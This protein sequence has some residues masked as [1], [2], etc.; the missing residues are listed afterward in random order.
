MGYSGKL[1]HEKNRNKKYRD[2]VSLI[3]LL[4]TSLTQW[5]LKSFPFAEGRFFIRAAYSMHG[6]W[7]L[8]KYTMLSLEGWKSINVV[9][10][11]HDDKQFK[12]YDEEHAQ[13]SNYKLIINQSDGQKFKKN[14]KQ[15]SPRNPLHCKL[16]S[17]QILNSLL[18]S[19]IFCFVTALNTN[20][21]KNDNF[22]FSHLIIL[23]KIWPWSTVLLWTRQIENYFYG[24]L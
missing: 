22:T 5:N 4:Y 3:Y 14:K 8:L 11:G 12:I 16:Q 10:T 18:L 23:R 20:K 1:I 7:P 19:E 15:E 21:F 9:W 17:L 24:L 6:F 13:D 2:N